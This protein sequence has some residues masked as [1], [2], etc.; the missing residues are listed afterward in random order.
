MP[1]RSPHEAPLQMRQAM[2][3]THH[4]VL[5]LPGK[6]S[7]RPRGIGHEVRP[8]HPRPVLP[9]GEVGGGVKIFPADREFSLC[10]R[11]RDRWACTRCFTPYSHPTQALHCM[12][13][14]GRGKW[15]TRFTPDNAR[16][17]CYGCHRYLD[18]HPAEKDAFFRAWLGDT[19]AD[20]IVLLSNRPSNG[21]KREMKQIA[22]FYREQF[23]ALKPGGLLVG[24]A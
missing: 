19:R 21:I 18:T 1:A 14:Q 2:P 13:W 10:I 16:A 24:Y 11:Q 8:I 3:R 9:L 22:K 17:G 4:P 7:D 12:H 20:E 15:A 23:R 6:Q 5:P